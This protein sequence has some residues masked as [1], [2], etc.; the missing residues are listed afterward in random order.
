MGNGSTT[1]ILVFAFQLL[2]LFIGWCFTLLTYL[3]R[4]SQLYSLSIS[5]YVSMGYVSYFSKK[6]G[7]VLSDTNL[8]VEGFSEHFRLLLLL[9]RFLLQTGKGKRGVT[10]GSLAPPYPRP[11]PVIN[12][13]L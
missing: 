8:E 7:I 5:G 6:S 10:G 9:W 13:L 12:N 4:L 1:A 3:Q 11:W 2:Y